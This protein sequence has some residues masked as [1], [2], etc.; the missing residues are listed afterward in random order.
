[1]VNVVRDAAEQ[2]FY[3]PKI[4]RSGPLMLQILART[5]F[6]GLIPRKSRPVQYFRRVVCSTELPGQVYWDRDWFAATSVIGQFGP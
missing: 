2:S 3:G 6:S 4:I 5:Q 1:M